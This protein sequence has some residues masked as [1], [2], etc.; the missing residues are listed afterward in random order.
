MNQNYLKEFQRWA[1]GPQ[2]RRDAVSAEFSEHLREA[3]EA[4]ELGSTLERLGPP[5]D[6]AKA[7]AAGYDLDPAPLSRRMAAAM[8]DIAIPAMVV[9]SV[10]VAGNIIGSEQAVQNLMKFGQDVAQEKE[11]EWGVFK[12]IAAAG[13]VLA[14]MWWILGLTIME[15][16]Y[17]RTPGKSVMGL[18]VVSEEGIALT[19]GQAVVRR[20]TLVF[21]GPLQLID[22]GFAL[23]N[24]QHQR[25]VEKLA[26]TL[27]IEDED[28]KGLPTVVAGVVT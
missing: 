6:A 14:M 20:L 17:G 5:R 24:P 21:S 4:G 10:I 12:G 8:I 27:V 22:W 15:W 7:F 16:R 1:A 23:F 9:V 18:R 2:A 13:L 19:F 3:E 25:A 28:S 11:P 26:H